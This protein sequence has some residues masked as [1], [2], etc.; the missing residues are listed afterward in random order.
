MSFEYKEEYSRLS[1]ACLN[2]TD[3]CN[4]R[5]KYCFVEQHPHYMTLETAKK[6]VDY[7]VSNLYWKR[8]HTPIRTSKN[9]T[10]ITFFGG[11]PTLLWDEIIVPV[12]KYANEKYPGDVSFSMTSNG[13]LLDERKLKFMKENNF[14]FLL[15]MDGAKITQDSN[16]PCANG[17][18]S[19]DILNKNLPKILEYYP[20]VT[21]R[22]TINQDTVS[23]TFEN[24]LF[25]IAMGF[26]NIFMMPNCRE[27]WTESNLNILKT[28][29]EKIYWYF[30]NYFE[31]YGY[32]PIRFRTIDESF[33]RIY[34]HDKQVLNGA[35]N[36][37]KDMRQVWRCG[38]GTTSGS[39]GYDGKIYGCQE[40]DSKNE[41][42]LFLIGHIDS[43]IDKEKHSKLLQEYSQSAINFCEDKKLCDVCKMRNICGNWIC[44][45]SSWDLFESFFISS[46][47]HCLW[48]Q[49]AFD[50]AIILMD[51]FVRN[52]NQKFDKFLRKHCNF[53]PKKEGEN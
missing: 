41:K 26:K 18:S 17:E 35:P 50:N 2:I 29:W 9:K 21:F 43:G 6:A 51:Y 38:L 25:A 12:V 20:D 27:N 22:A 13:I 47:T 42:N 4:L 31:I 15:S 24:Y 46:K 34:K 36:Y 37:I 44:P 10:Q 19:F 30:A 5:C 28:E 32:P 1:S 48:L 16:R 3:A 14:G 49:W 40:Q 39:I 7:L 52:N 23:H 8:E 53:F 45:S 33:E 11:E